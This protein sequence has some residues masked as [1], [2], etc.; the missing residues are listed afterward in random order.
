MCEGV[1]KTPLL[2][3]YPRFQT[4]LLTLQNREGV[5]ILTAH[6]EYEFSVEVI[7]VWN[8]LLGVIFLNF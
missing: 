4:N 3:T 5:K 8:L 6:L 1:C 2:L 7:K